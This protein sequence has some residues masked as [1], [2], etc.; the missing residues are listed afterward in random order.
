[1]GCSAL[2]FGLIAVLEFRSP[3]RSQPVYGS[4]L[5]L[6][7]GET[8]TIILIV[9][10][11][12]TALL[13]RSMLASTQEAYARTIPREDFPLVSQAV[14]DGKAEPIDQYVRLRSLTGWAGT[15]TKLGITGLPLVT[16]FLTLIFS[17][18]SLLPLQNSAGFLDLAKLTLGAFIGSFVQRSVEQRKREQ[19]NDCKQGFHNRSAGMRITAVPKLVLLH[20]AASHRRNA[21]SRIR[22]T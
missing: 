16:V 22:Y 19:R 3:S 2:I 5:A 18:I 7:S 15:F 4:W 6:I 9:V 14:V 8:T 21:A 17:A 10:G 1:M 12:L 11:I 20:R 13:G